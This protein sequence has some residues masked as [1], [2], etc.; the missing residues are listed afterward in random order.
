M[1][2]AEVEKTFA[3]PCGFE[4]KTQSGL[5]LH[6][7]KCTFGIEVMEQEA[8][9]TKEPSLGAADRNAFSRLINARKDAMLQA[10][11]DELDSGP[12]A[13]TENLR[14][15]AGLTLSTFQI[16]ELIKEINA[17]IDNTVEEGLAD[18]RERIKVAIADLGEKYEEKQQEMKERHRK[19]WRALS[20][21]QKE[22]RNKYTKELR[23]IKEKVVLEKA[24]E[25]QKRLQEYKNLLLTT[26]QKESEIKANSV[27]RTALLKTSR[28]R[29]EHA[30][31]DAANRALE[32]LWIISSR[33]EAANL[34][35]TI[36]TVAEALNQLNGIDGFNALMKRLDPS[37]MLPPP[38]DCKATIDMPAAEI[39]EE[40]IEDDYDRRQRERQE[41]DRNAEHDRIYQNNEEER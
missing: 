39:K 20:E 38:M 7:K 21:E 29:V 9:E 3:C 12:E 32:E 15:Q 5:T 4:A 22:E 26:Q 17:Q 30:I 24:G 28:K 14:R 41:R 1:E 23:D 8:K 2:V 13:I 31:T 33:T 11:A 10:L 6:T 16:E 27:G 19:E 25:L 34:V 18:E 35:K 37:M 40:E 36:P